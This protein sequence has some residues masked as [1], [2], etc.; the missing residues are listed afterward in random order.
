VDRVVPRE[1]GRDGQHNLERCPCD[2]LDVRAELKPRQKVDI[3]V[4]RF[5]KLRE[6][7]KFFLIGLGGS[8]DSA[9]RRRTSHKRT[10][11]KQNRVFR[12]YLRLLYKL[13]KGGMGKAVK[14][15]PHQALSLQ[16]HDDLLV[17]FRELAEG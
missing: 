2:G 4:E 17:Q 1:I 16:R 12:C 6:V 15:I 13:A 10:T 7:K 11:H 14:L 5:S 3:F 9:A 8:A